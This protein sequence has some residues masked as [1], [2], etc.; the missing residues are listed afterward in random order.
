M[1]AD[2]IYGLRASYS[3]PEAELQEGLFEYTFSIALRSEREHCVYYFTFGP[4]D[5]Q[6]LW[7]L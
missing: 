5:L 4:A 6:P 3:P 7:I 2:S 1:T